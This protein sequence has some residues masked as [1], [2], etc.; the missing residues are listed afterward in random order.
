MIGQAS[1]LLAMITTNL[2]I[3]ILVVVAQYQKKSLAV[4]LKEVLICLSF[5]RPAVD[6]YRVSTNHEDDRA[7]MDS[8]SEMIMNKC[9][10][11]ATESIPGC[12][13]QLYVWMSSPEQAGTYALVSIG[14]SAMTTG[15]ASAMISF[16]FDVDVPHRKKQ[17]KFYGYL[18]DDNGLRGR[19]FILMTLISALHNISRSLG[20]ALLAAGE[21]RLVAVFVVGELSLYLAYK[22]LRGDFYYWMKLDGVLAI[23]VPSVQ[24][25]LVKIIVDYTGCLHFRHPYVGERAKRASRENK[26]EERSEDYCCIIDTLLSGRSECCYRSYI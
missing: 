23:V 11:L 15:F 9:S 4:K 21:K 17:P 6:A 1:A 3:Q 7:P 25:V 19:S 18:P 14:V 26:N 20:Y 2:V 10:E 8:L 22:L 12:V 13:L 5:L 24:R 16:D